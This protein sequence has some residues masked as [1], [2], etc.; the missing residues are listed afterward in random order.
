MADPFLGKRRRLSF[1]VLAEVM[2]EVTRLRQGHRAVGNWTLAQTCRHLADSFHGSIDGFRTDRHRI[3]R[4]LFG[5]RALGRVFATHRIDEGF[6]VTDRLNPPADSD[7]EE[8][9]ARLDAALRRFIE[10]TGPWGIHPFFGRL[11]GAE[12]TRLHCIHCAHHLSFVIPSTAT[13]TGGR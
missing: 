9:A 12:W 4:T 6:T 7:P 8:S 3:M 2:P 1:T 10:H 13:P 11:T 5:R